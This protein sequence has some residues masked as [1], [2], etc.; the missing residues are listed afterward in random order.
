MCSDHKR[1]CA[2]DHSTGRGCLRTGALHVP[3]MG[4]A[5][6]G[7][8]GMHRGAIVV[9]AGSHLRGCR[10]RLTMALQVSRR[11]Q[12]FCCSIKNN[13]YAWI[14]HL[15]SEVMSP[16]QGAAAVPSFFLNLSSC[17][18][19]FPARRRLACN[20]CEQS[21]LGWVSRSADHIATQ[22]P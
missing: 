9:Q 21:L 14:E 2:R 4:T 12:C 6:A 5:S 7:C 17:R 8:V 1:D 3:A 10:L 16:I 13:A 20:S 22:Q 11:W 15:F 19:S 18:H